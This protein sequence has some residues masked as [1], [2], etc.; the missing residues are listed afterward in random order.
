MLAVCCQSVL[1]SCV[2]LIY[3]ACLLA[4]QRRVIDHDDSRICHR[5]TILLAD[6]TYHGFGSVLINIMSFAVIAELEHQQIF[7]SDERFSFGRFEDYFIPFPASQYECDYR[8]D[9]LITKDEMMNQ[10]NLFAQ[11]PDSE[12]YHDCPRCQAPLLRDTHG[13]SLDVE[14]SPT[15]T[16]MDNGQQRWVSAKVYDQYEDSER[17][18]K[19]HPWLMREHALYFYRRRALRK[20]LRPNARQTSQAIAFMRE[21]DLYPHGSLQFIAVHIRKGDKIPNEAKARPDEEYLHAIERIDP[22]PTVLFFSDDVTMYHSFML[23]RPQWNWIPAAGPPP[24]FEFILDK[25]TDRELARL[26][27]LNNTW[28]DLAMERLRDWQQHHSHITFEQWARLPFDERQAQIH[29]F[30]QTLLVACEASYVIMTET[31]NIGRLLHL[32]RGWNL[33][34]TISLDVYVGT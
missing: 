32:A 10:D 6:D 29:V 16:G 34:R 7:W 12:V 4:F 23:K 20:W 31:S 14:T 26:A 28:Y 33:T 27:I 8:E 2:V 24:L 19:Q 15:Y 30:F 18:F 1:I 13:W 11:R 9:R 22:S 25:E 21:H 17:F 5:A 3:I